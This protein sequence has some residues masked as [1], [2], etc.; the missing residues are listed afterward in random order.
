GHVE[1]MPYVQQILAEMADHAREQDLVVAVGWPAVDVDGPTS[2]EVL[3][4][5]RQRSPDGTPPRLAIDVG[6]SVEAVAVYLEALERAG[7]IAL[8]KTRRGLIK[9]EPAAA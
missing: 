6:I 3:A 9:A 7:L 8:R 1:R 4:A 5:V 2:R